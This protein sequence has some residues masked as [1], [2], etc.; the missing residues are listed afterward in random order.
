MHTVSAS[1][2]VR[3]EAAEGAK[4]AFSLAEDGMTVLFDGQVGSHDADVFGMA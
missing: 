4:V 1:R 3:R 2:F